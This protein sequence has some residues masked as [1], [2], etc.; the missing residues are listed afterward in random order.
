M[1]CAGLCEAA[2]AQCWGDCV[3]RSVG[4][5]ELT[6]AELGSCADWKQE[7]LFVYIA[8]GACGWLAVALYSTHT[9]AGRRHVDLV[10]FLGKS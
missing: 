1:S 9:Q 2:L 7:G 10:F 8:P 3:G 6:S 4:S 5:A